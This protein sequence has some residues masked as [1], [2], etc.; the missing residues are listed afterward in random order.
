MRNTYV[1][2]AQSIKVLKEHGLLSEWQENIKY[3][4]VLLCTYIIWRMQ[5]LQFPHRF[6]KEAKQAGC[7]WIRGYRNWYQGI[8]LCKPENIS[9]E[10]A[11]A[12]IR[13]NITILFNCSRRL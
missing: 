11:E 5:S 3:L 8:A 10:R 9:L 13:P 2:A 4:Q 12:F 6:S 7:D 1:S